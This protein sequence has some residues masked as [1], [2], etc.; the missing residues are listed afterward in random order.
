MQIGLP[1][2]NICFHL[3]PIDPECSSLHP[4]GLGA[5]DLGKQAGE[6]RHMMHAVDVSEEVLGTVEVLSRVESF[7][8]LSMRTGHVES[9]LQ[10]G[11]IENG[12]G[13]G[14]HGFLQRTLLKRLSILDDSPAALF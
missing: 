1:S 4:K 6:G 3:G 9:C 10:V 12:K 7:I 14:V 5:L 13:D 11:V 2:D 8:H